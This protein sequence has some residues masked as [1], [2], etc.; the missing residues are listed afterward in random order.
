M[1]RPA[2]PRDRP[3]RARSTL[4]TWLAVL[5]GLTIALGVSGVWA[6]RTL[7]DPE[8]FA[9]LAGDMLE[10]PSIRTE[11]AVVIVDPL[12]DGAVDGVG[13]TFIVTTTATVL[14]DERFIPVFEDVLRR[15][16]VQLVEGEGPVTLELD[17][18]LDVIVQ[19]VEPVSPEVAEM[20]AEIDAPEPVVVG[21]RQADQ[22]RG[23][24][25]FERAVSLA[26]L[27]VGLALVVVA[28]ILAGPFSLLPFGA[29]LAGACLVLFAVL[30]AG[31]SLLLSGIEPDSRAEAAAAAWDVVISDLT[32]ALL[33]SAGAGAIAVVAGGV[34]GR[35]R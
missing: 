25:A 30:L 19:E 17:R 1:A 27:I 35:R 5:A 32:I 28:V 31:R 9:A 11:L 24:V 22:L 26:L 6:Q 10:E 33:V 34:L 4:A 7:G 21:S 14:G 20:L 12:L 29:T 16:A 8:T 13:R 18:P 15:S 3:T 2:P 23:I